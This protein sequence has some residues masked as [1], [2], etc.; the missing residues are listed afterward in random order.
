MNNHSLLKCPS[1][2]YETALQEN[3]LFFVASRL[4]AHFPVNQLLMFP[5]LLLYLTNSF[6]VTNLYSVGPNRDWA[7]ILNHTI[8][9]HQNLCPQHWYSGQLQMNGGNQAVLLNSFIFYW[10]DAQC[11]TNRYVQ[12]ITYTLTCSIPYYDSYFESPTLCGRACEGSG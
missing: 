8:V 7:E 1:Y 4:E 3:H 6:L 9:R 12:G 5:I 2:L 11:W 10:R